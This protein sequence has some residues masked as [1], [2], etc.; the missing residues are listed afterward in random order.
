MSSIEPCT[1]P[2]IFIEAS[3]KVKTELWLRPSQ[4]DIAARPSGPLSKSL[5][6]FELGLIGKA[7]AT[8]FSDASQVRDKLIYVLGF[9]DGYTK[10][11][12]D[13]R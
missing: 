6:Q 4:E 3:A 9:Y 1:H 13:A 2:E 7:V 10:G 12:K 5:L 11:R 8:V